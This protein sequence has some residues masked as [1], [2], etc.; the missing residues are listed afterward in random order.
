MRWAGAAYRRGEIT[1]EQLED[2]VK[3]KHQEDLPEH[4]KHKR[5]TKE[6]LARRMRKGS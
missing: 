1:R 3:G 4:V 2:Y 6:Q 5:L